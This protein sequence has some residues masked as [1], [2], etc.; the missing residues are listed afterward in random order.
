MGEAALLMNGE[1]LTPEQV[2]HYRTEGYVVVESLFGEADLTKIDSTIRELTARAV[3]GEEMSQILELEPEAIDGQRVPRRIFSP[4]DQHDAFRDLA[5]DARILDRIESLIGPNF[6]LQ[7]SKLNMKP[8]KVGSVVDWHQDLAYFPHTND[9]LVTTLIY[10]DDATQENGCLQVLP[11][12]HH[13]YFDHTDRDGRFAGMIREDLSDGRFGRPVPLAAPAG[14][15]IFMHCITPHSSLPNRSSRARRTLIYEYRAADS[16][17][18]YYS[19]MTAVA[20]A[21]KRPIRGQPAPFA[22]FGGPPPLIPNVGKYASL[23]EL[24]AQSKH[25]LA[26]K[27]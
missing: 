4:Y 10:L 22:R 6:N 23:Y 15:V 21:K 19:E 1:P 16:Y 27:G 14:S 18:I 17:P 25:K 20:E 3:S 12:H 7:H 9:D 8:A 26:E 2:Q 5:H 13:H 24:Q 11:R